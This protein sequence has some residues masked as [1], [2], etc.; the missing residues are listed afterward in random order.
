MGSTAIQ[1]LP[2]QSARVENSRLSLRQMISLRNS[3]RPDERTVRA[4]HVAPCLAKRM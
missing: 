4:K 3:A 1:R 2:R